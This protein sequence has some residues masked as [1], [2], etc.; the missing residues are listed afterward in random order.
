[1]VYRATVRMSGMEHLNRIRD[2]SS[3]RR[4]IYLLVSSTTER[5][6]ERDFSCDVRIATP[7][8]SVHSAYSVNSTSL[9]AGDAISQNR[10]DPS[11]NLNGPRRSFRLP[12]S[13]YIDSS[14]DKLIGFTTP[15]RPDFW[16]GVL[17]LLNKG[18]L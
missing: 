15:F 9:L 1:M 13:S 10:N 7:Q 17:L 11:V 14:R 2:L 4:R 8:T 6:Q 3:D 18:K 5:V 12:C 16:S